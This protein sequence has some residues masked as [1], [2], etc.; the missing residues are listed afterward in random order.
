MATIAHGVLWYLPPTMGYL[1]DQL[2]TLG[3]ERSVVWAAQRWEP[4]R[5]PFPRVHFAPP[6]EEG[7][8]LSATGRVVSPRFS[9]LWEPLVQEEAIAALHVHDG[10]LA[11]SFLPLARAWGLPL[12]TTFLGRDVSANLE[13]P[14]YRDA[15][16]RLFEEG[17]RFIVMSREMARRVQALGG[18][19]GK[20]H[21]IHHGIPLARFPFAPRR[22][23]QDG[24]TVLLFAG[25]LI[26]KKGPDD[27]ARA[28]VRLSPHYPN[29]QLRVIGTGPLRPAMKAI[30]AE[31][32]ASDRVGFFGMLAPGDV[33]TEMPRAHFL[34]GQ[35]AAAMNGA[36]PR[37]L[38][39]GKGVPDEHGAARSRGA[40]GER[41]DSHP[42]AEPP[43]PLLSGR[44]ADRGDRRRSSPGCRRRRRHPRR[45]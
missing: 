12:V 6:P 28:F 15:L 34:L 17:D 20:I 37:A 39:C 10:R 7:S 38:R 45:R 3:P 42:Q 26:P 35:P 23:S 29:L 19:A 4:E 13:E 21:V 40:G 1:H 41:P 16:G 2:L 14:G 36:H 33:G 11:P 30:L 8:W 18:P 5:F 32:G 25:R 9:P 31:G 44:A 43:L 22:A 27:L 24:P